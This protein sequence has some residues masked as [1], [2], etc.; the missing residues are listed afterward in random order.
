[1]GLLGGARV[2][3]INLGSNSRP[4]DIKKLRTKSFNAKFVKKK[5][6]K[7]SE[8]AHQFSHLKTG[9]KLRVLSE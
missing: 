7:I 8:A 2:M 6:D 4:I 5:E 9:N 1:M 3:S